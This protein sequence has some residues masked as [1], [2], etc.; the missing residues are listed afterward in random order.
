MSLAVLGA[1]AQGRTP[2]VCTTEQIK[3]TIFFFF[4]TQKEVRS[5]IS[6]NIILIAAAASSHDVDKHVQP[7]STS[8]RLAAALPKHR[9]PI[10]GFTELNCAP[11]STT[12]YL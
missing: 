11:R 2:R 3:Y 9:T 8:W 5:F 1:G 10:S 4:Y 12:L 6:P 7:A